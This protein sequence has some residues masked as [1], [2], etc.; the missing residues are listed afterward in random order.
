[1]RFPYPIQTASLTIVLIGLAFSVAAQDSAHERFQLALLELED[2]D[3][4][5]LPAGIFELRESLLLDGVDDVVLQGAGIRKTVLQYGGQRAGA[6]GLKIS[7]CDRLTLIDFAVLNTAGDAIKTQSCAGI[8]FLR[9]ETSWTGKPSK[10]NGSYGLYPVQCTD[11]LI[12]A[13]TAR[14]ASDAGI[15]VGQSDRVVVRNCV[16]RE[17]VAGIEIENTTNAEVYDNLAEGNTG[18]IL[19]FDLPGLIKKKGG[20]VAVHHNRVVSNNLHNFAP[21]GN[22]VGQV[23]PGTGVMVLATSSVDIHD[24]TI[25]DNKTASV[26]VASYHITELPIQDEEYDPFASNVRI[27]DNDIVR[28][29]G[30]PTFRNKIGKLLA[31]KFGRNVPPI[32][33]DGITPE[34][35]AGEPVTAWGVCVDGNGV[36]LA[37]LDAA[38]GF[39]DLSR[40]PAGFACTTGAEAADSPTMP[41][42]TLQEGDKLEPR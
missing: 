4:L 35:I 27:A 28:R 34:A 8:N 33:Y 13:C 6:E 1:V 5:T 42:A 29:K 24:N 40:N 9:L 2:G 3:T 23:P 30:W 39:K 16:A 36:D 7:N 21:A 20:N 25:H 11:V 12:D 31:L 14:G 38:R 22:I 19:V 41:E 15:Y 26:A 37:N 18:G 32:I 17:N 10:T